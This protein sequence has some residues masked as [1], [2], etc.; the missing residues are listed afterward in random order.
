MLHTMLIFLIGGIMM[1][2]EFLDG[3]SARQHS[4]EKNAGE[5]LNLNIPMLGSIQLKSAD[6]NFIQGTEIFQNQEK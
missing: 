5:V 4:A 3:N 6:R 2:Y 1:H